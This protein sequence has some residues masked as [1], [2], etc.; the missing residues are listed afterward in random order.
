MPP[1][2]D[3]AAIRAT[4]DDLTSQDVAWT[5]WFAREGI[6]PLRLTYA[7][8]SGQPRQSVRRVLTALGL[9]PAAADG[10]EPGTRKL[11]DGTNEAWVARFRAAPAG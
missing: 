10:V 4:I 5:D 7:E 6:K 9:D 2:Y 3:A 8:V 1:G 11:A